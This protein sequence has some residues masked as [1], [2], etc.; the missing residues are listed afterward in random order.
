MNQNINPFII[1]TA[2]DYDMDVEIVQ[3]IYNQYNESGR[4]YEKLEDYIKFRANRMD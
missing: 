2:L 1:Q 4:F 3:D